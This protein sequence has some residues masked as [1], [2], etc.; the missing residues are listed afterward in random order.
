MKKKK[1]SNNSNKKKDKD[2]NISKKKSSKDSFLSYKSFKGTEN[3]LS[4]KIPKNFN[5]SFNQKKYNKISKKL[6]KL[7][8]DMTIMKNAMIDLN[9]NMIEL[10][11]QRNELN[12]IKNEQKMIRVSINTT[13]K[14]LKELINIVKKNNDNGY[15]EKNNFEKNNQIEKKVENNFYNINNIIIK[16]MPDNTI[17][18]Q[19]FNTNEKDSAYFKC[20]SSI[21]NVFR[22]DENVKKLIQRSTKKERL[23]L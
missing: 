9:K 1:T 6:E 20:D 4:M 13:N 21:N 7:E 16:D 17:Y 3:K 22:N 11:E 23:Y 5:T 2:D 19:H 8:K 18:I 12:N 14:L 15:N 10:K